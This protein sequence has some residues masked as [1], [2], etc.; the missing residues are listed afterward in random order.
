MYLALHQELKEYR[1]IK[2]VPKA[3]ADYRQFLRE[4]LLL[5]RLRHPGIPIVYDVFDDSQYSYLVEEF[6]EGNSIFDLVNERGPLNQETTVMYGIQI[7]DLIH[8]LHSAEDIPI[9]YLDLQPRNLIVCHG[10]VKLLD[11]DHSDTVFESNAAASRFGTPGYIAPEQKNRGQ[12]GVYTD[13]YQ[14]G[15]VLYYLLTG[16]TD[17]EKP[18]PDEFGKLSAVIRRCLRKDGENYY[19]A[20]LE[21]GEELRQLQSNTE[22][23]ARLQSPSLVIA[24]AGARPGAGVTHLAIG[25]SVYLNRIGYPALY[26][27]CNGSNDVRTMAETLNVRS[28]SYGI[29]TMFGLPM[30]PRYGQ[31][32]SL[33]ENHYPILVRD[34]GTDLGQV[35][36]SAG[37]SE[38]VW[39]IQGG[40]WWDRQSREASA[41]A[42]EKNACIFYNHGISGAVRRKA[43]EGKC[44]GCYRVPVFANPFCP[45]K[46][47][48]E[49][50]E[51]VISRCLTLPGQKKGSTVWD[52]FKKRRR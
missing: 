4:A 45:G 41:F 51:T 35:P 28:D 40:K 37:K 39:L 10:Q 29:Y 44:G 20:A 14:I 16:R 19:A 22:G 52:Y 33:R 5:K 11:F 6:L 31:A 50:Y 32:V 7:C 15:A 1:A 34:Y 9:L 3:A 17:H 38:S 13:I 26:E 8:Y 49:F 27:E 23:F 30:K 36:V 42:E 48:E 18:L 12:L 25:L 24:L 43:D 47:A 2:Q 21:V 46:E